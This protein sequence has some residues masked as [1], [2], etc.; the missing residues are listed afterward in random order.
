MHLPLQRI[1]IDSGIP[2]SRLRSGDHY[3]QKRSRIRTGA[4]QLYSSFIMDGAVAKHNISHFQHTVSSDGDKDPCIW[5]SPA[6]G[7]NISIGKQIFCNRSLNMKN[8]VAVG[9]DMDYTLAQY[10]PETFESLAYGFTIKKLVYDLGYPPELLEWSFDWKYMV[11]GL[12]LDKKR[13][14]ILKMDRHKYVKVAYHG[15]REMLKEEKVATYG[16]TLIRDSFDEPDY[17]LIDTLFSLAEAYLFAQLVDFKDNKPGKVIAGADY[18]SMYKDVRA[19]V[20]LCHRDGTL[21]QMVAEDPQRY[22]NDDTLIVPMLKMLRDSGRS[23]FLVTNSLWDYT[24][25]VMN[26]L[27]RK[28]TGNSITGSSFGWLQYF[29][30]VITGSAKPGFFHEE[31]RAN[32]FEVVPESGL[33]INTDN[34]TPMPQVGNTTAILPSKGLTNACQVFQGGNVAHLHKLLHI[35]SSS[36]VLYVGDHIYGD[37]LRSKKVLGWRTM[38]V[39]PELEREVELLWEFRDIRKQLRLLRNERNP[40]EDKLHRIKWSLKFEDLNTDQKEALQFE[41][42]NLEYQRE[43]TRLAHQQV[44]RELHQKF[45][46]VWGQ[47]MKTGYQNSRFAHQVERFACLYSSQ[48]TN[49]GLYSPDK[50]Y[51]TSEDFMPHE[52]DILV[53]VQ[54]TVSLSTTAKY[55]QANLIG[56]FCLM[57]WCCSVRRVGNGEERIRLEKRVKRG[58]GEVWAVVAVRG[59]GRHQGGGNQCSFCLFH[60]KANEVLL[61]TVKLLP[62]YTRLHYQLRHISKFRRVVALQLIEKDVAVEIGPQSFEIARDNY[63]DANELHVLLL[64][65]VTD[66]TLS[67]L[68]YT[69]LLHVTQSD[70]FQMLDEAIASEV[71]GL[72]LS[73]MKTQQY[74]IHFL[75]DMLQAIAPMNFMA[76]RDQVLV[77]LIGPYRFNQTK[78]LQLLTT[79]MKDGLPALGL[80]LNEAVQCAFANPETTRFVLATSPGCMLPHALHHLVGGDREQE[81]D[82]KIPGV[83]VITGPLNQGLVLAESQ[84]AAQF[85]KP[86]SKIANHYTYVIMEIGCQLEGVSIV[87]VM[88]V[89]DYLRLQSKLFSGKTTLTSQSLES[90]ITLESTGE[91]QRE[92]AND[93][94]EKCSV[95]ETPSSTCLANTPE[96]NKRSQQRRGCDARHRVTLR[97]LTTWFDIPWV[98]M[99]AIETMTA[100]TLDTLIPVIGASGFAAAA[101]AA[102]TIVGSVAIAASF[103]A[104]G[105]G[106][107]GSQMALEGGRFNRG[108]I[109]S[110][111]SLDQP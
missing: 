92:Y 95:V 16:N 59:L 33:L 71:E 108:K 111:P 38:L 29:D 89:E 10:K 84:L 97:L 2:S 106:L 19:A 48:V 20:D 79:T 88:L 21:K 54:N 102:G 98:K 51:R 9:F 67:A 76:V 103:G 100:P 23:T 7:D 50:Y 43:Q 73:R 41:L 61:S 36:Q 68:H 62:K 27:C 6:G 69:V 28:H 72:S 105:A 31:N 86:D 34:G 56:M 55:S 85:H 65:L 45:H 81:G 17:A 18:A 44:Q 109:L 32:I 57:A 83:E 35:E 75:V 110:S 63:D 60:W 1:R 80:E 104:V 47:L 37:I 13:G 14:N 70:Y 12:V 101:S 74:V 49:L 87:I 52:F 96:S 46:E 3:P 58:T 93:L 40:I 66:P 77:D 25:I 90:S 78:L 24:N 82:L 53:A 15:F 4:N 5:S 26:F 94:C 39:V 64:C 107:T 22:I 30:V 99:E 91:K 42:R 11:R 8:I